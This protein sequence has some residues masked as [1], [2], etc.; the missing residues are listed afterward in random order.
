M[1]LIPP[2]PGHLCAPT[3]PDFAEYRYQEQV[4]I[5]KR[6]VSTKK[7][8]EIC[9]R[10]GVKD[11][12]N[13]TVDH[14]IPLSLGGSNADSNLWCQHKSLAVTNIEYFIYIQ[15]RQNAVSQKQAIRGILKVKFKK[16]KFF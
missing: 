14:I 15:L 16:L 4:P 9:E 7:K 3:N 2:V 12:T 1:L 10:D 6:N 5:C 11:R 8:N 13:Y